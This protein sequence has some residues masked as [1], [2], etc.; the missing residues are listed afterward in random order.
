MYQMRRYRKIA[1]STS[2]SES[3]TVPASST[4][5]APF[6]SSDSREAER[7]TQETVGT[8][9][10]RTSAAPSGS[11]GNEKR[12]PIHASQ[13]DRLPDGR[14][15]VVTL[16]SRPGFCGT[17]IWWKGPAD[18]PV[19]TVPV[20]DCL[21]GRRAHGQLDGN[22]ILPVPTTVHHNCQAVVA[23]GVRGWRKKP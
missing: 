2:A 16:A 21:L 6:G 14:L 20:G 7:L 3:G 11:S 10:D 5:P 9:S 17:C 22:P 23:A 13:V 1:P 19:N 8:S 4:V 12:Q 15:D 18:H